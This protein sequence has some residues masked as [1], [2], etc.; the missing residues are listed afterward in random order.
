MTVKFDQQSYFPALRTRPAEMDGYAN[1]RDEVKDKLVPIITLGAWPR[2]EG[3]DQSLEQVE[4][5][6]GQR[7]YVLDLTQEAA[8]QRPQILELLRPDNNFS[9]WRALVARIG[10]VVPVVQMPSSAKLSQIIKQARA[11]EDA[12][13]RVAFRIVD[14]AVDTPRVIAGLSALDHPAEALVIIDAGYIRD[15]MPASLS[16]CVASINEIREE[17]P[18]AIITVVS[19]SFPATV[20]SHLALESAGERGALAIL[21]R[22]LHAAI[23][24]DAAIYGDHA[25]IHSKVYMAAGGRFMPRID[26]PLSD[27]WEFER[28]PQARDS[29]GYIAAAQAL[30]RR[31]PAVAEEDTWGAERIRNA[32]EG[33]IEKMKTPARWIAARVN[34]HV[35]RQLELSEQLVSVNEA[36]LDDDYEE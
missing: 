21:E 22:E 10:H 29:S 28:R 34:M 33:N 24:P 9:A 30:M 36:D 16:A 12:H 17:I 18:E 20:T 1:L 4:M 6:V 23:G 32:A 3:I 27:A 7:P 5:A 15:S 14:F 2:V 25:S 31:F 26:Y 13:D 19:T 35:T 8:Y 11:L